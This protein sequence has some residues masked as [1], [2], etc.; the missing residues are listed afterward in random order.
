MCRRIALAA[1]FFVGTYLPALALSPQEWANFVT[2]LPAS[3]GGTG[4]ADGIS[5]LILPNGR[6]VQGPFTGQ[7]ALP[8]LSNL[9]EPAA[10]VNLLGTPTSNDCIVGNGT[11]WVPGACPGGLSPSDDLA[12]S[13]LGLDG[14]S[15]FTD[16]WLRIG[17]LSSLSPTPDPVF[18]FGRTINT[19]SNA[20]GIT[21]ASVFNGV[22]AG[23]SAYNSY[24]ARP[25]I[26]SVGAAGSS[27]YVSFQARPEV[28]GTANV[29]LLL[30]YHFEPQLWDTANADAIYAVHGL[31][32]QL[33][34]S[35]TF[36]QYYGVRIDLQ[37]ATPTGANGGVWS[38]YDEG[39]LNTF[40][41]PVGLGTNFPS[42]SNA[43]DIEGNRTDFTAVQDGTSYVRTTAGSGWFL[44]AA[45]TFPASG[46]QQYFNVRPSFSP[47]AASS[48]DIYS[49]NTSPTLGTA[50]A[51]SNNV[52]GELVGSRIHWNVGSGYTGTISKMVGTHIVDASI[53]GATLTSQAGL[54]IE[55]FAAGT[56]RTL[57]CA[58]CSSIPTGIFS[59]YSPTSK[60]V[61]SGG[62]MLLGGSSTAMT[63]GGVSTQALQIV[64]ASGTG[65]AKITT[66][67]FDASTAGPAAFYAKS[68]GSIATAGA[69]Q[70]GDTLMQLTALGDD[71]GTDGQITVN[72]GSISAVVDG[73]VSSGTVPTK[74]TWSTMNAAGALA[75]RM[76]LTSA[77]LLAMGTGGSSTPALKPSGSTM[78]VRLRDDSVFAPIQGKLTTDT[79]YTA[80][81]P[82]TT[83]FLVVYDATGTAYEI[84]AKLH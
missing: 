74:W 37:T 34:D 72:G 25:Q 75:E 83:G 36:R 41:G 58:G 81:D 22:S 5:P 44:A 76:E 15:A 70:S 33:N 68:R 67:R 65:Y 17:T 31:P 49:I 18:I 3:P 71:G 21:D 56:N 50:A 80:G 84:P 59:I 69:V 53:G 6:V 61:F 24:D 82:T 11:D 79:N 40:L 8:D 73:S 26:Q 28:V 4:S 78:Q 27:H 47:S 10:R 14:A 32:I 52:T 19:T 46:T 38:F 57:I 51:N 60:N 29:P 12:I 1:L 39:N 43:L 66:A 42:T 7:G 55:N 2:G 62:Q 9:T 77:G 64:G 16:A 30:G 48:A 20:H 54:W 63:I 23:V 13:R 45:T 35:S